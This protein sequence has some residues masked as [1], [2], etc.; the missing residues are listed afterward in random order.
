MEKEMTSEE[1]KKSIN[2][3]LE[4]VT[5]VFALYFINGLING[6]LNARGE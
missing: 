4:N 2:N 3:R 1:L 5:D 6:F